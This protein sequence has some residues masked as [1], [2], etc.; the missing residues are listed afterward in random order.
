MAEEQAR[1]NHGLDG[2]K[3]L[4]VEGM[5]SSIPAIM[6]SSICETATEGSPERKQTSP[7][8]KSER[9][10]LIWSRCMRSK[11]QRRRW[12]EGKG[13]GADSVEDIEIRQWSE[14]PRGEV[15]L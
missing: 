15:I 8:G 11:N 2:E 10:S 12:V 3:V 4:I 9:K 1:S 14:E 5:Y 7:Q 13:G 6:T